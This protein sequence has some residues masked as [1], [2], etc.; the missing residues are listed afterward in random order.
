MPN[1]YL[2]HCCIIVNWTLRNKL[3]PNC[4]QDS[5]IF[6][7]KNAFGRKCRLENIGHFLITDLWYIPPWKWLKVHAANLVTNYYS[8]SYWVARMVEN[9]LN[10]LFLF[11]YGDVIM[12]AL[13]SKITSLTI[14]YSTVYSGVDQRKHQSSKSLAFVR[15]LHRGSV[16]SP[17]K[18]PLTR[19]MFPFDD[20]IMLSELTSR[21]ISNVLRHISY[22]F[23][24]S[25][26]IF[27][28]FSGISEYIKRYC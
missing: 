15:E 25:R 21:N 24:Q 20:V 13:P 26:N 19:K 4:I 22:L 2:N 14:V 27:Q 8:T 5:N 7:Q 6:I 18:W 17:H 16:N 3:Q 1:H 28:T 11:H 9:S 10:A 23:N 12:G